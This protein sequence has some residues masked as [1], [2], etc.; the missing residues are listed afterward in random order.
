[1]NNSLKKL[2]QNLLKTLSSTGNTANENP[3]PIVSVTD[4]TPEKICSC[5]TQLLQ[6]VS[7]IKTMLQNPENIVTSIWPSDAF[8]Y[9]P[10]NAGN[11]IGWWFKVYKPILKM[12]NEKLSVVLK[13]GV[14]K[15][16]GVLQF[17]WRVAG[18]TFDINIPTEISQYKQAIIEIEKM[19]AVLNTIVQNICQFVP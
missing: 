6:Q 2:E 7:T 8:L 4:L 1:M 3:C 16:R 11:S 9:G 18:H 19:E 5:A 12:D 14:K 10:E 15:T 17:P 13:C